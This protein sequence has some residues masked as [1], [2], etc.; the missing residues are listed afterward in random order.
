MNKQIW[1]WCLILKK[2]NLTNFYGRSHSVEIYTNFNFAGKKKKKAK[3]K[4][5]ITQKIHLSSLTHWHSEFFLSLHLMNVLRAQLFQIYPWSFP[6]FR[7]FV[8]S[9]KV[10]LVDYRVS[11]VLSYSAHPVSL[12]LWSAIMNYLDESHTLDK[13]RNTFLSHAEIQLFF[14]FLERETNTRALICTQISSLSSLYYL[15]W[16]YY[17]IHFWII[18][19]EFSH[20]L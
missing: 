18:S 4:K 3:R 8:C 14:C 15:H 19:L 11:F 10:F 12:F 7:L 16:I 13:L 17:T 2:V 1:S 20:Y 5:K 6:R 9:F